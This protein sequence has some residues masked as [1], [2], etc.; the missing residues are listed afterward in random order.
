MAEELKSL[1]SGR[2]LAYV[3]NYKEKE[4]AGSSFK[5]LNQRSSINNGKNNDSG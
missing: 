5:K 1:D 2:Q 4:S 3:T